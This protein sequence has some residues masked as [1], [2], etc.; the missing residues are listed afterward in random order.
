MTSKLVHLHWDP[1]QQFVLSDA[2]QRQIRL[3]KPNGVN[4]SDLLPMALIGC[5][6]YDVVE[7]L[8]K[9]RQELRHLHVTAEAVQD[10]TPPWRFRQI[11]IRYRAIGRGI[12]PQKL[13]KAIEISEGKYCSVYATLRDAVE[14]MNEYEVAEA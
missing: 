3:N 7:I 11:R 14:I 8:K 6:S 12:D 1:D 10:E 13:R 4:P 2:D 5:T 9:Q